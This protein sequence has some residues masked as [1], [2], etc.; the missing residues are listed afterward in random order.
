MKKFLLILSLFCSITFGTHA[1][2]HPLEIFIS[3]FY[4]LD[5]GIEVIY[6]FKNFD[7]A[8]KYMVWL[9]A[10]D[11]DGNLL[12]VNSIEGETNN[13]IPSSENKLKWLITNDELYVNGNLTLKLYLKRKPSMDYKKAYVLSTIFPGIGHKELGGKNKL[14]LGFLGYAGISGSIIMN[15]MASNNY[16]KYK[17]ESDPDKSNEY[18]DKAKDYKKYQWYCLGTSAVF[19][20]I[21]YFLLQSTAKNTLK[22]KP[23]Q[24]ITEQK[25]NSDLIVVS[26]S[27]KIIST[28]GKSPL[29]LI[30]DKRFFEP[31]NNGIL[32]S[33]E[34]ATLILKIKNSGEGTAFNI[35]IELDDDKPDQ[36]L[37]FEKNEAVI[38]KLK[39]GESKEIRFAIN[40]EKKIKSTTHKIAIMIT[41]EF[42]YEMK[43]DTF[44]F[45]AKQVQ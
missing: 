39:P 7:P 9:E 10:I 20:A 21:D 36:Y 33:N 22:M 18:L 41:S 8:D 28:K 31:N 25:P 44:E 34:N 6:G 13:V 17:K 16:D 24:I 40:A 45:E 32:E 14:A 12:E 43:P 4:Y 3:D 23:K 42:G 26:S 19:W 5:N 38:K 29:L 11:K 27:S 1:Q 2:F 30:E 37:K 15:K 35:K